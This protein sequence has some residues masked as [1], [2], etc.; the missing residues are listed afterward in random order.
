MRSS[1]GVGG[2]RIELGDHGPVPEHDDP[3][4]QPQDLPDVVGA[5]QHG[6]SLAPQPANELLDPSGLAG[7]QRGGRFVQHQQ[8]RF[9]EQRPG[10][11]QHLALATREHLDGAVGAAGAEGDPEPLQ[12]R[13]GLAVDPGPGAEQRTRFQTRHQVL[14]DVEIFCQLHV[15][16]E[17]GDPAGRGDGNRDRQAGRVDPAGGGCRVAC[18]TL[19]Q[20]RLPGPVLPHNCDDL[21]PADLQVD[22]VE[23]P[24][25]AELDGE[26][27][28]PY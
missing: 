17:D 12:H 14:G 8:A 3:V 1:I 13:S 24:Q 22:L 9:P 20:G 25:R 27:S 16:V 7:S 26:S 10:Q 11:S 28:G 5:E 4:R 19:D 21:A 2:G 18:D 15:L 6:P 23:R